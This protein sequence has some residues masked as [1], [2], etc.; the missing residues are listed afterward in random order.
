[1]KEERLDCRAGSSLAGVEDD[2]AG[3]L[4]VEW[5]RASARRHLAAASPRTEIAEGGEIDCAA[6]R[7]CC[8]ISDLSISTC[9]VHT[10]TGSWKKRGRKARENNGQA[11]RSTP[12]HLA[13]GH[14]CKHQ[15]SSRLKVVVERRRVMFGRSCSAIVDAAVYVRIECSATRDRSN[16]AQQPELHLI[17]CERACFVAED[18]LHLQCGVGK[19]ETWEEGCRGAQCE[20]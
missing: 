7:R 4:T 3:S 1:M 18:V 19:E 8:A 15:L 13:A 6:M 12:H 10:C 20:V 16:D 5:H 17:A 2:E 14:R 11:Q 9:S